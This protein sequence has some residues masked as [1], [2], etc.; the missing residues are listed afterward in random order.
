[1]KLYWCSLVNF[2]WERRNT[3][4]SRSTVA[5]MKMASE[6]TNILTSSVASMVSPAVDISVGSANGR[7]VSNSWPVKIL[8]PA[9]WS[10]APLSII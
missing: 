9:K 10:E 3:S 5:Q 7:R 8:L 2:P 4:E 1:M 6:G